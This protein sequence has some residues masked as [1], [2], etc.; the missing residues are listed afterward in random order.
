MLA[1]INIFSKL[2]ENRLAVDETSLQNGET[3]TNMVQ[4]S[5]HPEELLHVVLAEYECLQGFRLQ[6]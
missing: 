4:D 2:L 1:C 5:L 6:V 3:A